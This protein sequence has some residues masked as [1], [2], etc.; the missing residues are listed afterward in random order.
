MAE[1]GRSNQQPQNEPPDEGRGGSAGVG[2]RCAAPVRRLTRGR[3]SRAAGQAGSAGAGRLRGGIVERRLRLVALEGDEYPAPRR[4]ADDAPP[5]RATGSP[6]WLGDRLGDQGAGGRRGRS[7]AGSNAEIRVTD[8]RPASR[9]ADRTAGAP[10]PWA[11]GAGAAYDPPLSMPA[12]GRH[13]PERAFAGRIS[14]ARGSV[15]ESAESPIAPVRRPLEWSSEVRPRRRPV[16]LTRRGRL[17]LLAL[18]LFTGALVGFLSATPG[19]A[20]DPPKPAVTAVVQ[21]NDTLWSFAER[22]LPSWRPQAAIT[23]LKRLNDLEGYVIHPGQRLIL[24]SRR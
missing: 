1:P 6:D 9:T 16:R 22:N 12:T 10:A 14:R 13:G 11:T 15:V 21:P 18:I 17:V 24:P 3:R 8:A 20:A 2:A 23:E 19:Q 7:G 5:R 4:P